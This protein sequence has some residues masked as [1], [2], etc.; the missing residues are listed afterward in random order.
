MHGEPL[1][2]IRKIRIQDNREPLVKIAGVFNHVSL[3]PYHHG[4]KAKEVKS[5]YVRQTVGLMLKKA[6]ELLPENVHIL[7]IDGWRSREAQKK[8]YS[9]VYNR[10]KGEN[11]AWRESILR[12]VVN[13][14]VFPPD[15]GVVP[16]HATG[17]SVDVTLCWP[18]GRRLAMWSHKMRPEKQT[19]LNTPGLPRNVQKN[20]L[21]LKTV[22]EQ[23]GFTN[24]PSEWWHWSYGCSGWAVRTGRQVAIYGE[25]KPEDSGKIRMG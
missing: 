24:Y 21:I 9:Q 25:I 23:V 6:E 19:R 1:E 22:M 3:K 7:L 12:R 5:F 4:Q 17:G 10:L 15:A 14:F 2:E 13:E 11:P 18:N 8:L 20:R 16:Y